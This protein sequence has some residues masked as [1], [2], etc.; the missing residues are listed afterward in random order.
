M[1]VVVIPALWSAHYSF[2]RFWI[3]LYSWQK[4]EIPHVGV[5]TLITPKF[6]PDERSVPFLRQSHNSC[7][8]E[9]PKICVSILF[10]KLGICSHLRFLLLLFLWWR[11]RE[12][13]QLWLLHSSVKCL[14]KVTCFI[15]L[16]YF[17]SLCDFLFSSLMSGYL[18]QPQ[19]RKSYDLQNKDG[20]FKFHWLGQICWFSSLAKHAF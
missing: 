6:Y 9:P 13:E 10:C 18:C 3:Q 16:C 5:M 17:F 14:W 1:R 15:Y 19:G 8:S 11:R 7:M 20:S 12:Q 4:L 2:L